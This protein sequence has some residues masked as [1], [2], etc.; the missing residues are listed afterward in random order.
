MKLEP[1]HDQQEPPSGS[2]PLD[3]IADATEFAANELRDI[4]EKLRASLNSSW[5]KTN[6]RRRLN[7]IARNCASPRHERAFAE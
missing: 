2:E 3:R 6:V 1:E 7:Q 5:I 4:N